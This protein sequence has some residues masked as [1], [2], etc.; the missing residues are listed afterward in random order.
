[1]ASSLH[2]RYTCLL[3]GSDSRACPCRALELSEGSAA[4]LLDYF[5]AAL[6]H[7]RGE[8][9]A[10]AAHTMLTSLQG[11]AQPAAALQAGGALLNRYLAEDLTQVFCPIRSP[12]REPMAC[13][14]RAFVRTGCPRTF[15]AQPS[16]LMLVIKEE[17]VRQ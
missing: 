15:A 5:L 9:G 4:A 6:P 16:L 12:S 2:S 17:L 11:A 7:Q 1:M 14:I 13:V 3:N 10:L 8:I